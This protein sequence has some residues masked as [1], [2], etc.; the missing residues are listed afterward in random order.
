[1]SSRIIDFE[2]ARNK[3]VTPELPAVE[4]RTIKH[5]LFTGNLQPNA[6]K[7]REI[8][9]EILEWKRLGLLMQDERLQVLVEHQIVIQGGRESLR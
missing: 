8:H 9:T 1:M 2:K 7:I 6:K 5:P 3:R 4:S